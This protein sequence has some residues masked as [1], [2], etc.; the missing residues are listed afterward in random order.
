M[1]SPTEPRHRTYGTPLSEWITLTLGELS[2]D[3]VGLWQ[4]VNG[5]KWGYGLSGPQL[6]GA[7]RASVAALLAAGGRPVQGS[8]SDKQWHLRSDLAHPE[9]QALAQVMDYWRA[10]GHDPDLD[11]IWF[12]RPEIYE[13]EP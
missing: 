7:V 3:A 5:L 13:E 9:E 2:I 1:E 11:D 10:L 12:A 8:S 6:E 4:V